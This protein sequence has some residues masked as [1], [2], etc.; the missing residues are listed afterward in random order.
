MN[1]GG[2]TTTARLLAILLGL[3]VLVVL[4]MAPAYAAESLTLAKTTTANVLVGGQASVTLT[5]TNSGDVPD[6]NLSFRDQLPAGVTYVAGSTTPAQLGEP[7]VV[8]GGAPARQTLVWA[9][10]SDL[11]VGAVQALTFKVTIDP[12]AHPVG[13][14]VDNSGQAYAN[15]DPRT[16]PKFDATG[17]YTT[18]ATAIASSTAARTSISAIQVR[19]SEPSP[20]HELLRGIHHHPTRYT[21][22][23]TNNSQFPDNGVVLVDYLPAQLEFLG[24]G[25]ADNTP[26]GA[27]EYPGAPPLD[28][29]PDVPGCTGV[30]VPFSVDTVTNPPALTGVFTRVEWHLGNLAPGQVVNVVYAA[31]IPQRANTNTFPSGRP[32]ATSGGQGA[33]LDN[34]TGASTRETTSEQALTNTA[35]VSATYTGPV[36]VGTSTTVTDQDQLT[37]TAEDLAM[38]KSVSPTQF[39]QGG[40]ATYTLA[41]ED[42]EYTTASG[43]VITDVLP[44]GLCPLGG[45]GTNFDPGNDPQCAG[46]AGTAPSTPYAGDPVRNADGTWTITFDPIALA[47]DGTLTVT[48]QARMRTAYVVGSD[49]TAAG[50]SYTNNVSLTGTTTTLASVNPPGGVSST[51]VLDTSSATITSD[52]LALDK[53]IQP[54]TTS[55]YTCSNDP[56]AYVNGAVPSERRFTFPEDSRVCFTLRIDF[57]GGNDTKNPVLT[58]FLPDYLQLEPG[59]VQ[60]MPGNT[61]SNV[62]FDQTTLT[63]TMG[64][65]VGSNRFARKGTV[66]LYRLAGIVQ[67]SAT[68]TPDVTG[69]LA[70]LRW[71]NTKNQVSFLR[72]REDFSIAPPPPVA[73]LKSA[74]RISPNPGALA[75]LTGQIR[76][77]DLVQFTVGV[78]NNGTAANRNDVPVVG[79]DTW[80]RLP[81]GITCA[82]VSLISDSGVCTNPGAPGHPSFN[83]NTLQ[84]AIRW[85]TP[86]TL[87]IAAGATKSFT[88]RITYP[89]TI[90]SNRSYRNDVDVISYASESDRQTLVQHFPA[91]PSGVATPSVDTTVTAAQID[92]PAAHDDHT[93]VTPNATVAKSNVTEVDDTTQGAT[94]ATIHYGVIGETVTYTVTG[95]VPANTTIYNGVLFDTT[96][97]QLR[98]DSAVF[99]Y[100][101]DPAAAYAT[102]LPVGASSSTAAPG[103]RITLPTS[104]NAGATDDGF[105][106]TITATLISG[107]HSNVITNT[108]RLS[109]S[110][111]FNTANTTQTATSRVT[112]VEPVASPTKTAS[113]TN[114]VAGQSVTY[115][116]TARNVDTANPTVIRPTLFEARLVDCVPAGLTV[117]PA[118]LSQ[119]TASLGAPGTQGCAAGRTPVIWTVGDLAWRTPTAG[120]PAGINPWPVLT[121]VANVD[122]AA[123]GGATYTNTVTETGTS[124]DGTDPDERTSYVGTTFATITV[125]GGAV[126]KSVNPDHVPVGGTVTYTVAADLPADVNFYDATLIDQLPAGINP[127]TVALTASTCVF[128]DVAAGPCGVVAT[129]GGAL[130]PSGQLHGWSLGTVTSLP[131]PR[132]VTVVYTAVVGVVAGNVAGTVLAN[133]ARLAWNL[134][135]KPGTP[136]LTD[137][138]D[139][140]T[141]PG[142]ATTTVQEPSL[143][144]DKSV[145]NPTPVPGQLF[146]YTVRVTNASGANISPANDVRVVDTIPTGVVPVTPIAGGGVL[147]GNTITWTGLGPVAPGAMLTLSYQARLA[148]P[149]PSAAQTNTADITRYTSLPSGGGRVYDGPSDTATVTPGLPKLTVTKTLLD[150]PPSYLGQPTRWQFVVTNTGPATAYDVDASDLL[151]TSWAYDSGSARISIAGGAATAIEPAVTGSPQQTLTWDNLT[152]LA[153]TETIVVVLSATPDAALAP[154]NVG[155]GVAHVNTAIATGQ[156]LDGSA[157]SV[158]TQDDDSAQ[159]RI[160]KA[161]ITVDKVAVG[162][163]VAGTPF[164]WTL[165]VHNNGLD[166]AVGPFVVTDTLPAQVTGATATGTGWTCSVSGGTV[167]CQRTNGTDILG[168]GAT[169]PSITVTANVPAGLAPAAALVN[170]ATVT[171]TTYDPSPG[172]NSDST[173]NPV[174]TVAD[175]GIDKRLSGALVPGSPATYTID[176]NNAGPSVARGPITVTDTLPASLSYVSHTGTGWG[177]SRAGQTLTFTWTGPLPV[178]IGALPQITVTVAVAS[179]TTGTVTNTAAV[180]EPTDP[181]TGPEA[182][183]SDSVSTTPSPSADLGVTKASITAFRA[184]TQGTYELT[185][186]DFGPSDAAGPLTVTD[187]L[188]ADLTFVSMSSTDGWSCSALGQDLTCSR[189]AGLTNGATTTFQ[190]VVAIAASSTGNIHNTAHVDGPTPDANPANDDESDDTAV[191]VEADLGIVKT[192]TTSP[193]VAGRDVSYDLVVH[194]RG[195]AVSP[196]TI[197]VIDT[198]PAGLTFVSAAGGPTWSCSAAGQTVTCNRA[199]SLAVG[200]QAPTITLV[201]HV[202]SGIGT[203]SLLNVATV[204]GP[205]TDPGPDPNTSSVLANVTELAEISVTKTV[206]GPDPVRAGEN[207]TFQ[208]VVSSAGP[209]DARSVTVSDVLPA[210][211]TL[212]SMGGG[213]T[214]TCTTTVCTIDRIVAGTSAAPITVEARV[215]AGTP[216]GTTLTNT[217]DV[218]TATPGDNPADNSA[219]APVGVIARAD[220]ELVKS[221]ATGTATAGTPTDF[222]L[223]VTNHGPSDAVAPLT[224]VDTLPAGLSYLSASAP[225]SCIP[226]G[227]TVTCTLAQGLLSGATA[228]VLTLQVQVAATAPT[229][230]LTNSATV[231]SGTVDPV[232]ANNTDPADV[233]VSQLTDLSIVKSHAGTAKVGEPLTWNL[234]VSNAGPSVARAVVV[235]DDLPTGLDFVSADGTGWSCAEIS[236]TVTCQLGAP[237]A[238]GDTADPIVLVTTVRAA[239]YPLVTNSASVDTS[240]PDANPSNDTDDDAVAVPPLVNLKVAKTHTGALVVGS[241][242]TYQIVVT[243][244]GPTPAPGPITVTDSLPT[245]LG[246]LSASGGGFTCTLAAPVVTCLRAGA[247]GVGETATIELSV[248]VLPAAYPQVVNAAHVGSPAVETDLNDNDTQDP[249]AV[250]PTVELA[251][252]KTVLSVTENRVGYLLEVTNHGPS[253]TVGAV[254]LRDPLPD[255]LRLV[256]AEGPGWSCTETPQLA[257]CSY[258]TSIANGDSVSVHLV[259]EIVASPGTTMTNVGK[260][261]GGGTTQDVLDGVDVTVPDDVNDPGT[262][263]N[264]GGDHEDG[265]LGV[266]PDTGGP[267]WW[268][269]LVG[270]LLTLGGAVTL[271]RRQA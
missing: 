3:G 198:L 168:S 94:P 263:N 147:S 195:P 2:L 49:P 99:E 176:V 52:T 254:T 87:T 46:S 221:H 224:I 227:A 156:D 109:S 169:F 170:G 154:A 261:S 36:A 209:S 173:T 234:L 79:P 75:D 267:A 83:G 244:A 69:N 89:A 84:S 172:N 115:T 199:T 163:P 148:T 73:V 18:G 216:D 237:L 182:P 167:T 174:T 194:N 66:F 245:G 204:T 67:R 235:T 127:A 70:K 35:Q 150:G 31:G 55:P 90:A 177:L 231:S 116:V 6:Y 160:D 220:L 5:A 260:V 210:G 14:F 51:T 20:E 140:Q 218:T 30:Q 208:V 197:T 53:R 192:L 48:Y 32:T 228:P 103:P 96:P 97:A 114:P 141:T 104:L 81:R 251:L 110:T 34:N 265:P 25:T 191:G 181:T 213:P 28:G 100:R 139:Q 258:P 124:M 7:T 77:G 42:G 1:V 146:T 255:G 122:P 118:S 203:T 45:A 249:G 82:N 144:I 223:A 264:S 215:A 214:W 23:V 121:Y 149:A 10:V 266:L 33:N 211:M 200:A 253:A 242:A 137:P 44:D 193:V 135:D 155:S 39:V 217:V 62:A 91:A 93:L 271:R 126:T 178:A 11:P 92:V 239:A 187:T 15:S 102:T 269:L 88:Y 238:A 166:T 107:A 171:D 175:L 196:G 4:P 95:T 8:T 106:I 37:V 132:R 120:A 206:T 131:R 61:V 236:R 76:A 136:P 16:I 128:T 226:G 186:H 164:S 17:S 65:T 105:R 72:D 58:D 207:A 71:T 159:T 229:G 9:N 183:D 98:V 38:Q 188:P 165:T 41:L 129:T 117:N 64:D 257:V 161:D 80:D 68:S 225:W 63:F 22:A 143:T 13:D 190:V 185:V 268:I 57:P 219:Q 19:K 201:A 246:Y 125:P 133:S 205:V 21:L 50:D 202:A 247:L 78:T 74:T 252:R 142:T 162:T 85:N 60:A 157:G 123:A 86:D 108:A 101:A 138:Y 151:P 134:T 230:V 241:P 12:T 248:D 27:V 184:G 119:P 111:E 262:G 47:Q 112:V 233:T 54:I 29:T 158:V 152:D 40:V 189:A 113:P 212:V 59:S 130:G 259:A 153:T 250:T 179:S 145:D 222:T 56:T 240:T 232:P 24:C 270:L 243:N 43:V 256:S 180:T 26:A